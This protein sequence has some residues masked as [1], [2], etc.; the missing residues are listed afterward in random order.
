MSGCRRA[1]SADGLAG[2]A[3]T[4]LDVL[5]AR[6]GDAALARAQSGA[7]SDCEAPPF[8]GIRMTFSS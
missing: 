2:G 3:G 6:R 8:A 4:P 7:T 5:C 1:L